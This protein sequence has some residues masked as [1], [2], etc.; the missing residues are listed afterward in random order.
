[1]RQ[2]FERFHL[3]AWLGPDVRL[4]RARFSI[5]SVRTFTIFFRQGST[6]PAWVSVVAGIR[7]QKTRKGLVQAKAEHYSGN[8]A[9]A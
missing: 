7:D 6:V 5:L 8:A 4:V 9:V 2:E 3:W 1:M